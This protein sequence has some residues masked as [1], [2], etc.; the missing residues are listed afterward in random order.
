M[1]NLEKNKKGKTLNPWTREVV[2][3]TW[4]SGHYFYAPSLAGPFFAQCFGST[5]I[6]VPRQFLEAIG[7]ISIVRRGGVDSDP[8]VD[9]RPALPGCSMEKCARSML[10]FHGLLE[11]KALGIWTLFHQPLYRTSTWSLSQDSMRMGHYRCFS[12]AFFGGAE[13]QVIVPIHLDRLW[14]FASCLRAC[15]QSNNNNYYNYY[16]CYYYN[17]Y[18]NNYNYN[19]NYIPR[20]PPQTSGERIQ[21]CVTL[22]QE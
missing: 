11:S 13:S 15:V 12:V 17:N 2:F 7:R 14:L 4:T 9:S 21:V 16:Y 3:R 8:V 22:Q 5:V 10:R 1:N 18:N 20:V 19:Y 6:H